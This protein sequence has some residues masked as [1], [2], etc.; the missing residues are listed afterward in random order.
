MPPLR[1][2]SLGQFEYE[3]AWTLM[4]QF[5]DSRGAGTD[6]ELWLLEHPPVF[7][8]GQAGLADHLLDPG[9]IPVVRCDRGGQVTYHGPG[10]LVAYLLLDLKRAR[11]GVKRLVQLLEQA[12]IELLT[13][14]GVEARS[15]ADAPGVYV[16]D[17][18]IASVG[19]R[20]RH[21]CSYHGIALNVDLDLAPFQRINPCGYPD[22]AI[23][24]LC[25]QVSDATEDIGVKVV[26]DRLAQHLASLLHR[27]QDRLP[28][29]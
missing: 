21:G 27:R 7:T 12:V 29:L 15:R 14:Y 6:D 1:V 17:A 23:T 24:R 20:V 11:L 13:D 18:K 4:R 28:P 25:D 10:Q 5:T 26:G 2:R 8:L 22:L 19:L 3:R 9:P 16:G